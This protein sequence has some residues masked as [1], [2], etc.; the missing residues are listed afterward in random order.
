MMFKHHIEYEVIDDGF[1]YRTIQTVKDVEKALNVFFDVF[2]PEEP[3]FKAAMNSFKGI[4]LD[5]R[6]PQMV[7]RITEV[8]QQGF[9]ILVLDTNN[10]PVGI[11]T[12]VIVDKYTKYFISKPL[13][14]KFF[15]TG[16][17]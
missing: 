5:H 15:L 16:E 17:I 9:S 6:H 8:L 14:S 10:F 7:Q 2:L 12:A 3:A 11:R 1:V 13:K 4:Q